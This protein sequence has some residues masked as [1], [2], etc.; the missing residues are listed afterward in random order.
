M[1]ANE[2]A[3]TRAANASLADVMVSMRDGVRLATDVYL[4][5]E[6]GQSLPGAFPAILER[7]PYD[8]TAP[9]RSE[10]TVSNPAPMSRAEV[11][12]F[13]TARGYAVVYQDCRGTHASEGRFT[14][15]LS[16]GEDGYDAI[17]WIAA[18]SWCDGKVGTMG[19][20]Y[21]AHAQVAAACLA[22]PAL[23]AM[24]V[25]SGGFHDAYQG[26]I[27]Q[28]GAFELKQA[29]WAL[30]Q[31]LQSPEAHAD[32]LIARALEAEMAS[33]PAWFSR[34]PW[35]RGHSPLRWLPEFEDYL[36]DQWSHGAYDGFWRQLGICAKAYLEGFADVPMMHMSSWYDPYP[37]TATANF[38]D[39]SRGKRG[40]VGLILGPWTHGDRCLTWAGDVDF[41]PRATVE[42]N[43]SSGFLELRARWFDHWLK[44]LSNGVESEPR[45]R[46]FRMGGGSGARDEAGRLAHG[47]EWLTAEDWPPPASREISF[48]LHGDGSLRLSPAAEAVLRYRYDPARPVPSIGGSITS[49]EPVMRGGAFDQREESRFFGC[50]PPFLPLSSRPDVL[51][52]ETESLE[53]AVEITGPIA[54]ELW[55][56]SDCPDTDFTIKLIDLYP[57]SLDYPRG[58]AMNLT[59][60]ILRA[61]YRDSWEEPRFMES[62]E[63]Y[64][65]RVEAFPTSN[66]FAVGHRI[67]L[68]VSSSNFPHFDANPNSGESEGS[69]RS[70]RIATNAVHLGRD[71]PTRL[72]LP[73]VPQG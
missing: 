51:V 42:G 32:P 19:L 33:V 7:T 39:L 72:I 61:R 22:P 30:R 60:G 57:P 46:Y 47:G 13:F 1:R 6:G 26:G 34:M 63:V 52:F 55:I 23:A 44:G 64:K 68:D 11:A 56:S 66:L 12:A 29:T 16:E 17:A 49:G 41:G 10:R 62:G 18:Q 40:P 31:A 4:P 48:Y 8:K 71:R 9:S 5:T 20:S 70:P 67:R 54:A 50:E 27:R 59:D 2:S 45:V 43:L 38:R 53:R 24:F 58:F 14:K 21:A 3:I 73:L 69:G 65:I 28:G 35:R 36:F 15:Y 37:R 25:D